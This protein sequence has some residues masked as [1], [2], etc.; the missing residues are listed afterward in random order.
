MGNIY[1]RA[2]A[3]L[4]YL[5]KASEDIVLIFS[6]IKKITLLEPNFKNYIR[7]KINLKI[8]KLPSKDYLC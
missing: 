1:E 6:L 2:H 4:I 5:N 8:N 3:Y 7:S